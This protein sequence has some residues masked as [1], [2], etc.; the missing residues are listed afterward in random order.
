MTWKTAAAVAVLLSA[1][2]AA[3]RDATTPQ[4]P[5]APVNAAMQLDANLVL[6]R[7][8]VR[9]RH[10]EYVGEIVGTRPMRQ[11]DDATRHVAMRALVRKQLQR[12][13]RAT[14]GART[15]RRGRHTPAAARTPDA[16]RRKP[17]AAAR[18]RAV[19]AHRQARVP[20]RQVHPARR[21]KSKHRFARVRPRPYRVRQSR[22][23]PLRGICW[24]GEGSR[25]LLGLT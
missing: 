16:A 25:W 13:T 19:A 6:L 9:F 18:T 23:R 17:A 2:L 3:C 24:R 12:H 7:G 4:V 5:V 10:V 14:R 1:G 22:V 8:V 11:L 20:C 15:S 21:Q